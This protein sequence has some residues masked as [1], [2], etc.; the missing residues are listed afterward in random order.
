M[1]ANRSALVP[2]TQRKKLE[3]N[4]SYCYG[5]M[6][7]IHNARPTFDASLLLWLVEKNKKKNNKNKKME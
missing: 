4:P 7:K 5:A 2:R 6:S 1:V 3:L